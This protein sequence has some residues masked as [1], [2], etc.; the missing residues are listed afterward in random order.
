[1]VRSLVTGYLAS[2]RGLPPQVWFVSLTVLINR[3]GTMVLPFLALYMTEELDLTASGAGQLLAVYGVGAI[4]GNWLG[5]WLTGRLGPLAVQCGS[6]TLAAGGFVLLSFARTGTEV[7]FYLFLLSLLS[8]A[9][10]PAAATATTLLCPPHAHTRGFALNRLAINLGMSI[11]P[12][13]GGFLAEISFKWLF[14]IDGI[15]SLAAAVFLAATLG[16]RPL[17]HQ[18]HDEPSAAS[19]AGSPW[20][21]REFLTVMFVLFIVAVVFMQLMSTY[22]VYL[23]EQFQFSKPVIGGVLAINTVLIVLVEMLVMHH[24]ERHSRLRMVAWGCL[25]SG[26]GFG[27]LPF[28]RGIA[29]AAVL[30]VVFTAGEML[31]SAPSLA[32]V[33]SRSTRANRSAYLAVYAMGMSAALVVAPVVGMTLY[34]M[35]PDWPWYAC[36]ATSV[37]VAGALLA[38]E[39]RREAVR[40]RDSATALLGE[41]AVAP[42]AI[43]QA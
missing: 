31:E 9:N 17:P 43:E 5:G 14:Y 8:E 20:R 27:L 1:M 19:H 6:L 25:L 33:A 4:L 40:L 38:I 26:L 24:T 21:D 7:A 3:S 23:E 34:E 2:F 10:R 22:V 35:D 41:P 28:G 11:G 36:L 42:E 30:M 15:T 12:V 13:I 32:Y 37:G 18:Q 39:G 16:V 29:Y